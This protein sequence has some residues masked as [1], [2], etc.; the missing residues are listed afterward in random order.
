MLP[1]VKKTDTMRKSGKL[2]KLNIQQQID[3]Q[4]VADRMNRK[5]NFTKNPRHLHQTISYA[6]AFANTDATQSKFR[7]EPEQLFFNNYDTQH[8]YESEVKLINNSKYIQRIKVTPLKQKEFV[9][10]S[11]KYPNETTGD[12]APGMAVT[13][14]VRFRP[15]SLNDYQD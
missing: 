3:N 7:V 5:I 6:Q 13:I 11:I 2:P 14:A 4:Q 10:A 9:L 1:E 15:P 8:I 12:I